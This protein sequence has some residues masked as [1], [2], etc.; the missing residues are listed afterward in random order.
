MLI[1]RDISLIY[2]KHSLS[3]HVPQYKYFFPSADKFEVT[4]GGEVQLKDTVDREILDAYTLTVLV[5]DAGVPSLT[6]TVTVAI[7]ITGYTL[8]V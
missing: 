7:Q 8:S 4:Q 6:T 2:Y 5:A 3:S 1:Y